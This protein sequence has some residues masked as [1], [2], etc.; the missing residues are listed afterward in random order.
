M[1]QDKDL[2]QPL[3][4]PQKKRLNYTEPTVKSFLNSCIIY[5]FKRIVL[6]PVYVKIGIYLIALIIC[7][8]IKDFQFFP[9]TS[10]FSNKKN[11]FNKYLVKLGWAWTLSAITPFILMTSA[12]YNNLNFNLIK[13][14]LM[15]ILIA[16]LFWFIVTYIFDYI[17]GQTGSCTSRAIKTKILCKTNKHEWINGFDISGHTF[18]L[19]HSLFFMNEE[20]K[21]FSNLDHYYKKLIDRLDKHDQNA[22]SLSVNPCYRSKKLYETLLP[23]IKLN[24]IFIGFLSL[25]WEVMLLSTCLYFHTMMHKVLAAFSAIAIWFL[26]Y[27]TWY[28]NKNLPLSPGLPG[29]GLL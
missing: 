25:I 15:R 20:S 8:V 1:K 6:C 17:D 13:N 2:N 19:M 12:I 14:H 22:D 21:V 24:F 11:F 26:T 23:F 4:R 7:S 3:P 10:Y 16:S 27:K 28:E 29:S 5:F 18:I 9:H